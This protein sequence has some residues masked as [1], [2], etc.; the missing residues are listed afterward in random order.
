MVDTAGEIME[1]KIYNAAYYYN[2]SFYTVTI[3][4]YCYIEALRQ[5][6]KD[7]VISYV[8]RVRGTC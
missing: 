3:I 4:A 8:K 1:K 2:G 5:I 7:A 6:P